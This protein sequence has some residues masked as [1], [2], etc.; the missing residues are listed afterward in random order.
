[1]AR[2]RAA[3]L[4]RD[5]VLNIDFG[6]VA[7]PEQLV[8]V[9]GAASAV[10]LLNRA[11]YLVVVVSN[12]SGVARGYFQSSAVEAFHEHLQ[13]RLAAEGAHLD[14]VYWCPFHPDGSVTEFRADH[15]DRKPRPGMI[16]RAIKDLD[17]EATESFLVG[18]K[19]IDIQ[20]A[21]AAGI[22]GHLYDG[23]MPLDQFVESIVDFRPAQRRA[24]GDGT[25]T[26]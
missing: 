16:L 1:M 3:F 9:E 19:N 6:Y 4:D 25:L 13:A 21:V 15:E 10:R 8:L 7:D 2:R 12:Q 5:G 14:A 26:V 23:A 11:G 18:D 17:I 20:A 24:Q 22:P